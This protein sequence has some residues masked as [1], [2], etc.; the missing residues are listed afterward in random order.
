MAATS[1]K[2]VRY[3]AADLARLDRLRQFYPE[4]ANEADM[5]RLATQ[6][7]MVLMEA[8]VAAAGGGLPKG[9]TED[10][11]ASVIL[12][13]I[14]SALTWLAQQGRLPHVFVAPITSPNTVTSDRLEHSEDEHE[15]LD[16][17]DLGAINDIDQL[18]GDFL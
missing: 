12:P 10:M 13:R 4:A 17:L 3:S 2:N 14:L 7:G 11:L 15:S 16:K 1:P 18:G 6:R 9:M 8:E 5:I